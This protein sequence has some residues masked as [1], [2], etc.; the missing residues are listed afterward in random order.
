MESNKLLKSEKPSVYELLT[1]ADLDAGWE[2]T[3]AKQRSFYV[4]GATSFLA[5]VDSPVSEVAKFSATA[6]D[7]LRSVFHVPEG[8]EW[9]E[10]FSP[11]QVMDALSLT[12]RRPVRFSKAALVIATCEAMAQALRTEGRNIERPFAMMKIEPATFYLNDFDVAFLNNLNKDEPDILEI[13]RDA[14]GQ[15]SRAVFIDLSNGYTV[16]RVL[17]EKTRSALQSVFPNRLFGGVDSR[18][19]RGMK[20]AS[21]YEELQ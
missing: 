17:A 2:R 4:R 13:L 20:G 16:T 7:M 9:I 19:H 3:T 11:R 18:Y 10:G 15:R 8:Q 14:T 21:S 12:N 5:T 6:F 1:F